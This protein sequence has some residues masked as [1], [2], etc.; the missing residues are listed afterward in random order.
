MF[1]TTAVLA[2]ALVTGA[3]VRQPA[4]ESAPVRIT[5][6]KSIFVDRLSGGET[7]AQIRDMI[8]SSLQSSGL[9]LVTENPDRADATLRGSAEDLIYTDTF[10]SNEGLNARANIGGLGSRSSSRSGVY[11]GTGMG[12]SDS[13][14]ISERRH[15]ASAAVRL[16]DRNGDVIWATTQESRGGKFRGASADVADKITRQLAEDYE[17]AR[18]APRKLL[19][20]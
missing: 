20:R 18:K 12:D 8:I 17:R 10:S 9:F 13:T 2:A 5:S 3:P 1:W 14:R 16:V 19:E 6:V 7:A 15:E 11:A 4:E